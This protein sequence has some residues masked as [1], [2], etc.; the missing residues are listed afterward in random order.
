MDRFLINFLGTTDLPTYL[1]GFALALIGAI[2]SLRLHANSRDKMSSNTP[3]K[4]N[5][6]FMIQDNIQRLF[7]GFLITFAAFR[8]TNEIAGMQFTMWAA[9]VIGLL[10]DQVAGLISKIEFKARS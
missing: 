3:Y 9:F 6:W 4:F 5:F 8:F 2:L 7:T 10:N 1:A